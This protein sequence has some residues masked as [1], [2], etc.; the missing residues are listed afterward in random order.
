MNSA[1]DTAT[2]TG[3]LRTADFECVLAIS[4]AYAAQR[5]TE[6]I[7]DGWIRI[8][9]SSDAWDEKNARRSAS[10]LLGVLTE[11]IAVET[12]LDAAYDDAIGRLHAEDS[13]SSATAAIP[14]S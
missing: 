6:R 8:V 14:A 1:F 5:W 2:T 7:E 12:R 4:R 13:G 10:L 11:Y 3:A 9:S